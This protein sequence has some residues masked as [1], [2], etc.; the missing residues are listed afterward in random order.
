[1]NAEKR[2]II[3]FT[4]FLVFFFTPFF[5]IG[6]L[7]YL[8]MT[9]TIFSK[10]V[11]LLAGIAG[12]ISFMTA[13]IIRERLRTEREAR[14]AEREL[15]GK[16]KSYRNMT[17]QERD[18]VQMQKMLQNES[19]LSST[20]YKNI[21]KR[22]PK[23]PDEE[24]GKLVGLTEVKKGVLRYKAQ[25][26]NKKSYTGSKH[27]C[28]LGNPGTGK[29]TVAGILTA[30]LHRF[31]YVRK[32]EYISVDGNFFKSGTDPIARTKM[33]LGRAKGK[34]LFIDEAYALA[35]G[36]GAGKEILATI[37]N[38]MENNREDTII[39]LAGYKK[40]MKELFDMNSGLASRIKNYFIFKD[41]SME[42][43][44]QIFNGFINRENIVVTG[45]AMELVEDVLYRK[46]RQKN[47]ANARTVRN[48]AEKCLTEH[49][50]NLMTQIHAQKYSL[51]PQDI[52][53]TFEEDEYFS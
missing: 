21:L 15:C 30:Y 44:K 52:V 24:L 31:G 36:D 16:G 40:E 48:F 1:M 53:T 47:F 2:Y 38:E 14:E 25:I 37:L 26:Q 34:V 39:I 49:N 5:G 18:V 29:T 51:L 13:V 28:F 27:M 22:G 17:K 32:N 20:E 33:L 7:G 46:R 50:Y 11:Y 35:Q 6:L 3:F 41:Y 8:F 9:G 19:L 43:L 4:L 45:D 12:F 42:E 10:M 23:F